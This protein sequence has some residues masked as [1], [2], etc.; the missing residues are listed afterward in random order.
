MTPATTDEMS[1]RIERHIAAVRRLEGLS[2][3]RVLIVVE[4]N[5]AYIAD[6]LYRDLR[7]VRA[8]DFFW[9][10]PAVGVRSGTGATG[11]D[12][13]MNAGLRTTDHTKSSMMERIKQYL[14][15]NRIHWHR[16][17][18]AYST[19]DEERESILVEQ[20]NHDEAEL[21]RRCGVPHAKTRGE[22]FEA[23]ARQ[24]Q[25]HGLITELG[26]MSIIER[27]PTGSVEPFIYKT[28]HYI[29]GKLSHA[30]KDDRVMAL[31]IGLMAVVLD[32]MQARA[33]GTVQ[34]AR[35]PTRNPSARY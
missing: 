23:E 32:P 3:A 26:N 11:A 19:P 24:R 31:G 1:A 17:F 10:D 28:R 2:E 4:S 7:H 33:M 6:N 27:K 25:Q 21:K 29:T 8:S 22:A 35:P 30:H 20:A 5:M 14:R 18:I 9:T 12:G 15:G 16:Q 34:A 13:G